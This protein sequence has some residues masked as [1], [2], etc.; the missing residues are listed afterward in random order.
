M[1]NPHPLVKDFLE[2]H[3]ASSYDWHTTITGTT[4]AERGGH[5]ILLAPLPEFKEVIC[6]YS[7]PKMQHRSYR[8]FKPGE[9]RHQT[10]DSLR[11]LFG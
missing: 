1:A 10:E 8:F 2:L 3:E 7:G 4:R 11:R 9:H 6:H 5:E